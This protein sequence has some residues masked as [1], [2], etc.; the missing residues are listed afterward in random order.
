MTKYDVI[1]RVLYFSH[2]FGVLNLEIKGIAKP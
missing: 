2:P 1:L